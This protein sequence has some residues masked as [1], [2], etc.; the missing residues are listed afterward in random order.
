[1]SQFGIE[2]LSLRRYDRA[3]LEAVPGIWQN[4]KLMF[5]RGRN[6]WR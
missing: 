5:R 2:L 6:G 1:V 3:D 4:R